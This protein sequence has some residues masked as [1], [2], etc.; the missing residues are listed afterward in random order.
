M[1]NLHASGSITP[2]LD[3]GILPPPRPKK[4]A[5]GA[6][7]GFGIGILF[8][9]VL[10]K[11]GSKASPPKFSLLFYFASVAL[12]VTIHE[13]DHLIAGWFVGFHFSHI[14]VGPI[15]VRVEYGRLKVQVRRDLGALGYAGMHIET[16]TRLRRRLLLYG[17]EGP[18][19]NLIS[20]VLAA[21]FISFASPSLRKM[22]MLS[23]AAGFC[24]LSL[25][26]GLLSL[27]PYGKTLRSDGARRWI[28]GAALASQQRKGIQPRNWKR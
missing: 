5:M 22:W 11:F 12:A 7:I 2:I 1:P 10:D 14:S 24:L 16:V 27:V 20:G 18:G 23:F 3:S 26:I 28:T 17:A 13:L 19:A 9:V 4:R 25:L 8:A 6:V 15:S 21:L